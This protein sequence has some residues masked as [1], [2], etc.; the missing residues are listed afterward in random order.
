M[1][2]IKLKLEL[3]KKFSI[4]FLNFKMYIFPIQNQG[5][6]KCLQIEDTFQ[7][8]VSSGQELNS[9]ISPATWAFLSIN[10]L[11]PWRWLTHSMQHFFNK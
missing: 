7:K 4:D 2:Q 3:I 5:L 9:T 8:G 11:T 6:Q 1:L 10:I